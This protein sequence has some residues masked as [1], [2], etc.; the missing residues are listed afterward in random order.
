MLIANGVKDVWGGISLAKR[1]TQQLN[2]ANEDCNK[3]EN[4]NLLGLLPFGQ[5]YDDPGEEMETLDKIKRQ[6]IINSI[7]ELFT[8]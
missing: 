2:E 5:Y 6:P 7:G 8:L 1:G 4:Q 3:W